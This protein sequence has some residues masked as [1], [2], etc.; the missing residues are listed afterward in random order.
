[1]TYRIII[2][3]PNKYKT[4]FVIQIK[5]LVFHF[6]PYFHFFPNIFQYIVFHIFT[7]LHT[8]FLHNFLF[9][10]CNHLIYRM[11]FVIFTFL[12]VLSSSELVFRFTQVMIQ[13]LELQYDVVVYQ[14]HQCQGILILK[15]VEV[16]VGRVLE[17]EKKYWVWWYIWDHLFVFKILRLYSLLFNH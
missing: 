5:F 4:W 15:P 17:M 8:V 13:A 6:L 1:M 11:N 14:S 3:F 16:S 12:V 2:I 9:L 7:L 10:F